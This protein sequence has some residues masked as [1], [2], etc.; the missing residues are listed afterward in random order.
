MKNLLITIAIALSA[1][2]CVGETKKDVLDPLEVIKKGCARSDNKRVTVVPVNCEKFEP[3]EERPSNLR[4]KCNI[5][6][7][8][9]VFGD[10]KYLVTVISLKVSKGEEPQS[11][12]DFDAE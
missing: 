1:T 10:K 9:K 7:D 5:T 2:A 6:V 4:A 8:G 3:W 11:R 12:C